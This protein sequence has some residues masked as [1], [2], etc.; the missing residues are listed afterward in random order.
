MNSDTQ[1]STLRSTNI[2]IIVLG[3]PVLLSLIIPHILFGMQGLDAH[4]GC[5]ELLQ[6]GC[7]DKV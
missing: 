5:C 3:P 2:V 1:Q 6:Q 4:S 7:L